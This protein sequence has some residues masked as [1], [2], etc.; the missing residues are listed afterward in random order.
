M[1]LENR[2]RDAHSF[3]RRGVRNGAGTGHLPLE[4]GNVW[5]VDGKGPVHIVRGDGAIDDEV[6][7]KDGPELPLVGLS[8]HA[9]QLSGEVSL[10]YLPVG[11]HLFVLSYGRQECVSGN[12][13]ARF[14]TFVNVETGRV[15]SETHDGAVFALHI[16]RQR[17]GRIHG[18][19]VNLGDVGEGQ[20]LAMDASLYQT[21]PKFGKSPTMLESWKPP[22]VIALRSNM[23]AATDV[24]QH[25]LVF[26]HGNS[27]L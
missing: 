7:V 21:S 11:E 16:K 23:R 14:V 4:R 26:E 20:M 18:H 6:I 2:R 3:E 24:L 8:Q 10:L 17:F 27:G 22:L 25:I 19:S 12:G 13:G 5:P 1:V 15:L 9:V